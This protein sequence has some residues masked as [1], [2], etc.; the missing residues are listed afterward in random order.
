MTDDQR[1]PQ[2]SPRPAAIL[3]YATYLVGGVGAFIGFATLQSDPP[4]LSWAAL[5]AVGAAGLLSFVRHSIMHKSDAAR[6]G[7]TTPGRNN[8][9]IE[10]GLANLAWGIVAILAVVLNWGIRA[11]AATFLVFGCYLASV[12]V[13]LLSTPS[14]ERT[15]PW[16]QVAGMGAFAIVL[17][18]LGFAGMAAG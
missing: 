4:S 3:M 2:V 15:R 16:R 8:F 6:M 12:A 1:Q 18:W 9:Q 14:P 13:M 10:V 17:L 7:W 5:L 11:E